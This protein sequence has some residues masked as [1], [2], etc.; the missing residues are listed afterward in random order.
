MYFCTIRH[1]AR[2]CV[3]CVWKSTRFSL[4]WMKNCAS[5]LMLF[6]SFASDLQ[7]TWFTSTVLSLIWVQLCQKHGRQQVFLPPDRSKPWPSPWQ[8]SLCLLRVLGVVSTFP[9]SSLRVPGE[10]QQ[11]LVSTDTTVM[12]HGP[13]CSASPRLASIMSGLELKRGI[14]W[15]QTLRLLVDIII[16]VLHCCTH[17]CPVTFLLLVLTFQIF[18]TDLRNLSEWFGSCLNERI[19]AL[20]PRVLI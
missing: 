1:F 9:T 7:L 18:N 19:T 17:S 15:E 3:D 14:I 13:T 12:Q 6:C 8:F 20:P 4:E 10:N 2:V 5:V 11:V 16:T